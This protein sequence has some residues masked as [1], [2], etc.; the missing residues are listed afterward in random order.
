MK[1]VTESIISDEIAD[2][3][4]ESIAKNVRSSDEAMKVSK[5]MEK[6]IR[7]NKC[8]ILQSVYQQGQISERFKLTDNFINMVN[9]FG[10][11]QSTMVFKI[12]VV[13]FL[14]KYPRIKNSSLSIHFVKHKFKIL[15]F[16]MKMLGNIKS[17]SQQ[18]FSI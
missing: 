4:I 1:H 15:K 12:A 2:Q 6:I 8:S 5:Q 9:Q 11:S 3:D 18:M 17:I 13:K 16:A 14:N 7:I 10:I